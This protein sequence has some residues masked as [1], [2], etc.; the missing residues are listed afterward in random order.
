MNVNVSIGGNE[1]HRMNDNIF[2]LTVFAVCAC[3]RENAF[4]P[5]SVM[6]VRSVMWCACLMACVISSFMLCISYQWKGPCVCFRGGEVLTQKL[7]CEQLT[8]NIAYLSPQ[9]HIQSA[10]KRLNCLSLKKEILFITFCHV[11][12]LIYPF[13]SP[14]LPRIPFFPNGFIP[15]AH[16]SCLHS[17]LYLCLCKYFRHCTRY[18][19]HFTLYPSFSVLL[20]HSDCFI[21]CSW[22]KSLKKK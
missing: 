6:L 17:A 2:A 20:F 21:V 3:D 11:F 9:T 10:E 16:T 5:V 4:Y 1:R 8:S 22:N 13:Y 18:K 12:F 14:H 19:S 7:N 15:C